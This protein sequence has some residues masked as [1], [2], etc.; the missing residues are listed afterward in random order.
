MLESVDWRAEERQ[1]AGSDIRQR[2]RN[3]DAKAPLLWKKIWRGGVM[4]KQVRGGEEA[5]DNNGGKRGSCGG[6][7]SRGHTADPASGK[8]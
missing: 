1:R 7:H 2:I 3:S 6:K 5:E 8:L 4:R